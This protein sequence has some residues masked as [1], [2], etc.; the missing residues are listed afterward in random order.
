MTTPPERDP[1]HVCDLLDQAAQAMRT[2]SKRRGCAVRLGARGRLLAT[3]DLHDN[4]MHLDAILTLARLDRDA[5]HHVVLHEMIHSER[6]VNG[7][8]LSH[9]ML[10]RA[11]QLVVDYPGQV[12]VV[13]ANHELSQMTG[14]G[15][16]KGAGN[17]VELFHDGLE[18]AFGDAWAEVGERIADFIAAMPLALL[19]ESGVLC[20]HSLP[21]GPT[22]GSFD[23]A[24][25]ERA[26]TEPDYQR[27]D[28]AAYQMVWGRGY[29]AADVERF[30]E[31][32][33]VRLFCLGHQHAETGIDLVLPNVLVINSDHARACAVPI[34]L[35]EPPSGEEAFMSAIPLSTVMPSS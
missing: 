18:Y 21:A 22:A 33:G 24:V 10:V 11:A 12:H 27:P 5:D 30:S 34:D 2:D 16:S 20:A 29:A 31:A 17:N 26:L 3:G 14:A 25:L 4:P 9:R 15:V 23:T 6:L 7:V 19:S 35:A 28:G 1:R 13:L 32:W 8:D